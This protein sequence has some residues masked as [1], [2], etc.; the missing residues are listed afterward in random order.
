M[1]R[2]QARHDQPTIS[3]AELIASTSRG[4]ILSVDDVE[5]SDK[6]PKLTVDF[7]VI[8]VSFSRV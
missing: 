3:F 2:V 8:G 6:L 4:T 1:K 5:G 7:G